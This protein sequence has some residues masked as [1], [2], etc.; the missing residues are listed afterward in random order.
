MYDRACCYIVAYS[1]IVH[2][3]V[4]YYSVLY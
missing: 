1:S 4:L 3:S 2:C